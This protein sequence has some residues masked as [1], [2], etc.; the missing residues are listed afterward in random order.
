MTHR[1]VTVWHVDYEYVEAI[2]GRR[3]FVGFPTPYRGPLLVVVCACGV[4]PGYVGTAACRIELTDVL[5]SP[6]GE[7]AVWRLRRLPPIVPRPCPTGEGVY[8]VEFEVEERVPATA[9]AKRREAA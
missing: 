9:P 8:D 3:N 4:Q 1:A 6:D 7:T 5:P 2:E